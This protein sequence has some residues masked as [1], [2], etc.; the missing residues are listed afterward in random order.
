MDF[1]LLMQNYCFTE[2]GPK[3]V[4][5]FVLQVSYN[6]FVANLHTV[7]EIFWYPKILHTYWMLYVK[8]TY[9]YKVCHSKPLY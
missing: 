4:L 9:I 6:F 3:F 2:P 5:N 8:Y 1:E 7:I